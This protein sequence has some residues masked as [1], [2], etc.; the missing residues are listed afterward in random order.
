MEHVA[1]LFFI[2]IVLGIVEWR[3]S[4]NRRRYKAIEAQFKRHAR[5]MEQR[6]ARAQAGTDASLAKLQASLEPINEFIAKAHT[7][8][9]TIVQEY[10]INGVPLGYQ[11]KAPH[12]DMVE[13]L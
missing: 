11:R 12:F 1:F 10:E 2:A 4:A 5:Q 7:D 9:H 6:V 8:L 13:G 3:D